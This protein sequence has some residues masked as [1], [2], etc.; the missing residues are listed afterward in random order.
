MLEDE[1][2]KRA[3][4]ICERCEAVH[5]VRIGADGNVLPIGTG[6]GSECNCGDGEFRVLSESETVQSSVDSETRSPME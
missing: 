5:S 2:T 4:A 1:D 3:V 6:Q